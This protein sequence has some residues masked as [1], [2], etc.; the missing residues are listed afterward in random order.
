MPAMS[1]Y[2]PAA[3]DF[4][5]FTD[6]D[7]RGHPSRPSS[8]VET[9]VDYDVVGGARDRVLEQSGDGSMATVARRIRVGTVRFPPVTEWR[10]GSG[11]SQP[12]AAGHVW[13]RLAACG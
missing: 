8:M 5:E 1:A 9:A 12:W 3:G 6:R 7:D 4:P 2:R 11:C 13:V 10:N